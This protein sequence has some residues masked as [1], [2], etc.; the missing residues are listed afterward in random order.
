VDNLITYQAQKVKMRALRGNHFQLTVNV[1]DNAGASYDF[2]TNPLNGNDFHNA[3]FLVVT[4]NGDNVLNYYTQ[5]LEMQTGET[6]EF[7]AT[8]SE[9]GKIVIESTNDAGFWPQ[10]GTYKYNLFTEYV[11]SGGATSPQQL[12]H[13][14]YGDFI[15]EESN[16]SFTTQGGTIVDGDTGVWGGP[17]TPE[18]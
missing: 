6:I 15:V 16:S 1:K 9:D 2:S 12:T 5:A 14:L 8:I 10:P 3:Y 17:S 4:N 18:G 7:E 11:G 13:W